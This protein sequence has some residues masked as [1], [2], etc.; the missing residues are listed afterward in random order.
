[1]PSTRGEDELW[2]LSK[3]HPGKLLKRTMK[4]LQRYL[5][6]IAAEEGALDD[7]MKYRMLGYVNQIVLT[8]HPPS[9]IGVRNY[10]ELITLGTGIDLLLQGRLAELG[11]LMA[12]RLKALETSLGETGWQTARHQELIPPQ[13]ASLTTEEERRRAARQELA[14][15]KLR[16]LTSKN[17]N[18]VIK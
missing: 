12:Q 16:Q 14:T 2:R 9:S 1:M 8:Q 13:A 10:R 3:R 5:G 18:Q 11:D 6:D 7:W 15:S 4:E 17:R